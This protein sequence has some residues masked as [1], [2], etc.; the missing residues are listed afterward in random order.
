M[1]Y[2]V[3]YTADQGGAD[4]VKLAGRL[5]AAAR[6][7]DDPIE[8]DIVIVV[9]EVSPSMSSQLGADPA[10]FGEI[11]ESAARDW[12]DEA[13]ALV[14][15]DVVARAH[16]RSGP[17]AAEGLVTAAEEFGAALIVV[18]P[19]ARKLTRTLGSEANALLHSSP[20]PVL[21]ATPDSS[22]KRQP[23]A[24][25]PA[26]LTVFVGTREGSEAVALTAAVVAQRRHLQLRIVSLVAMDKVTGHP[27]YEVARVQ[28]LIEDLA[29]RT[30]LTSTV[31]ISQG[32]DIEEAVA[33]L[34]WH[35]DELAII[36]SSR[37]GGG[38][39]F[40]GST[41]YKVVRE[42]PVPVTVIPRGN[43]VPPTAFPES[44]AY[45]RPD[46]GSSAD[47]SHEEDA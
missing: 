39:L 9:R 7:Q 26:R 47:P 19:Q 12:A 22:R 44:A 42:V 28:Q 3:G 38:H 46:L 2:V 25:A 10:G 37:L 17:S 18:A 40:L 13:L 43:G 21:L 31:E 4:A 34:Q 30:T 35:D 1:R 32:K 11:I 5:A 36:G 29:G 41:A 45:T 33:S 24:E 15:D 20:V 6:G 14:P 27:G 23:A 8:L 16:L